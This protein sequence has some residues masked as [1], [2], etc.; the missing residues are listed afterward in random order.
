[1]SVIKNYISRFTS[2]GFTIFC[3]TIK[4]DKFIILIK[5]NETV[6][7][8]AIFRLSD[9]ISV[10]AWLEKILMYIEK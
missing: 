8:N 4:K 5:I 1:M 2:H 10:S 6:I 9:C 3:K 7:Y